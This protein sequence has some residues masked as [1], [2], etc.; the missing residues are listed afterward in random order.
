MLIHGGDIASAAKTYAIAAGEWL[1]LSTGINP[2]AYPVET[3][4]V[5][6]YQR[7]PY[8]CDDFYAAVEH[9]YRSSQGLAVAGTQSV[10]QQLPQ[11]LSRQRILLAEPGYAEYA[12]QFARQGFLCHSYNTAYAA[13]AEAEIQA[14]LEED[15]CQHLLVINPNNPTAMRFSPQRL[16]S[17]AG[18]L[19]QPC[20]LVVDEAF[21][22]LT[23]D[24]SLLGETLPDNVI[25]LRSFGKFFGLAGL[26]L[27]FVFCA[28]PLREKIAAAQGPWA[29]NGPAQHI[30]RQALWD[31][32]WQQQAREDIED[33][34][35][36]TRQV[37]Q[38][39]LIDAEMISE[40]DAGLFLSYQ[41]P[42]KKAEL[43]HDALARQAVLTR[44]L[45]V[46]EQRAWLR[47]G[48]ANHMNP[49]VVKHL[50]QAVAGASA[51]IRATN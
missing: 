37:F 40:A 9:Y 48:V 36:F 14:A 23:P 47:I 33:F 41:L 4:P 1:D 11:L 26:R 35:D 15:N 16:R 25:V 3:V 21:I 42:R 10:I 12:W 17:W 28:E 49:A 2:K 32:A 7:L 22:D 43:L 44:L 29:V 27:G 46:N 38:R 8:I 20:Y 51:M 24:Q 5:A 39:L 34:C 45:P 30:A 13:T 19:A 18:M 6:A 50:R 31:A